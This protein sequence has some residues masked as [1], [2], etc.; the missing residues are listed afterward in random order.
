VA[1]VDDRYKDALLGYI[2]E[3]TGHEAWILD[4]I[5]ALGG[6]AE[7]V[8][9]SQ[10]G[11]ACGRLID[12][13]Y[14][15][16]D[17]SGPYALMGMV[18]VLEGLSAALAG[19]AARTLRRTLGDGT[20]TAGFRYLSSH[21]HLDQEHVA[22]FRTLVNGFDK[23]AVRDAIVATARTVYVLYGDIFRS[24]ADGAAA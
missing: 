1:P 11:P 12:Y 19:T 20:G 14:R 5:A 18:H 15:C 16:I 2:A 13:A 17:E 24:L 21:G 22:F 4:D 23:P 7:A 9:R 10:P 8:S 6:D 3:E